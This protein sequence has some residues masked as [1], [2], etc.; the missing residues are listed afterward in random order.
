MRLEIYLLTKP[1]TATIVSHNTPLIYWFQG[2]CSWI[3][4]NFLPSI[5][6]LK[7]NRRQLFT[8]YSAFPAGQKVDFSLV[9]SICIVICS[10]NV[11]KNLIISLPHSIFN[12]FIIKL[13]HIKDILQENLYLCDPTV[14]FCL[15][16][17]PKPQLQYVCRREKLF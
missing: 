11:M 2:I 6:H 17:P 12:Q 16:H 4:G 8:F 10:K 1:H 3:E 13:Y 9:F 7:L 5:Q 14:K 15:E